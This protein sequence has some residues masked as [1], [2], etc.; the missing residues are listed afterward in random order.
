MSICR[1]AM[2][3]A[4]ALSILFLIYLH[5]QPAPSL[6]IWI[7]FNCPVLFLLGLTFGNFSALTLERL[8]HVAGL[9]AAITGA[10]NTG[11]ALIIAARIGL[12]FNSTVEPVTWGYAVF[13]AC[14]A[15]LLLLAGRHNANST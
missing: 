6:I 10:L 14:T 8:G 9:A 13:T 5:F 15:Y 4:S 2:W 7:G 11:V 1:N 3:L 12:S